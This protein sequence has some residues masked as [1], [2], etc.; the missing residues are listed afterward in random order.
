MRRCSLSILGEQIKSF[1]Y[2][3][4]Y[5]DVSICVTW[6]F[7]LFKDTL[8]FSRRN[9]YRSVLAMLNESHHT[10]KRPSIDGA[11][12]NADNACSLLESF[13]VRVH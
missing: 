8:D 6:G 13:V 3:K 9:K 5:K 7:F 11:P 2:V 12:V 10:F 4:M 1:V